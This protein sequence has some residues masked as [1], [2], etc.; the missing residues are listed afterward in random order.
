MKMITR[1]VVESVILYRDG[2]RIVLTTGQKFSFT[3]DECA[4]ITKMSPK[5]LSAKSLVDLDSGDADLTKQGGE[6]EPTT[7]KK[8]DEKTTAKAGGKKA[9]QQPEGDL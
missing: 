2:K 6:S 4:Q 9:A 1:E 7:A 8:P 3:E 5:A